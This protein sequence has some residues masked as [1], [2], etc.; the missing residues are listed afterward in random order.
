MM[1]P[2]LLCDRISYER[3]AIERWLRSRDTSPK[4][5]KR[6]A[7]TSMFP[8][9]A[10]RTLISDFVSN[11]Y[12]KECDFDATVDDEGMEG[13]RKRRKFETNEK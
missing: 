4:T 8:N 10:L 2:V 13:T 3:I 6:L 11:H 1:D 7:S 5:N 9:Q 12:H